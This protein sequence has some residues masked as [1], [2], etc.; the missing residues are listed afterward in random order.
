MEEMIRRGRKGR[1]ERKKKFG[2][3]VAP[4]SEL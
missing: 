3:R 1:G 2:D 4:W